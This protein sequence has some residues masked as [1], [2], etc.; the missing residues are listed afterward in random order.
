MKG[1]AVRGLF[2]GG[3][4]R[5]SSALRAPSPARGEGNA[6]ASARSADP[7]A[8]VLLAMRLDDGR[9]RRLVGEADAMHLVA[10]ALAGGAAEVLDVLVQRVGDGD[11]GG[12]A[13][14]GAG[15]RR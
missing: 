5:P 8:A 1:P 2:V 3:E 14:V 13:P 6:E 9:A 12:G 10:V 4:E 11:V 7:A 15:G